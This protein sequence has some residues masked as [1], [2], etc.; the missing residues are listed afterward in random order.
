MEDL[1]QPRRSAG[2]S[3]DSVQDYEYRIWAERVIRE[4]SEEVASAERKSR[5]FVQAWVRWN[6]LTS[7]LSYVELAM[8]RRGGIDL[9]ER[10][11]H[12]TLSSGLLS[13][14]G[15]L[16]EWSSAFDSETLEFVGY[17]K[18]TLETKLQTI[19]ESIEDW[20]F[21]PPVGRLD[22]IEALLPSD[23]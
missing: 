3:S 21:K 1:F 22:A 8:I 4:V 17:N 12:E 6:D 5:D 15:L 23:A 10:E 13:L 20:H 7:F 18:T 14:G 9:R 2:Y 16:R 19:R 11:W